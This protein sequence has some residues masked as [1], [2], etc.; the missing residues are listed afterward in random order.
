MSCGQVEKMLKLACGPTSGHCSCCL[1]RLTS[2]RKPLLV[3]WY[4]LPRRLVGQRKLWEAQQWATKVTP[5]S[6]LEIA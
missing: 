1:Q 4:P 3:T 2:N 6:A 5:G